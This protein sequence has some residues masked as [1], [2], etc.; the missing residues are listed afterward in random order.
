MSPSI[1]FMGV[2]ARTEARKR[3]IELVRSLLRRRDAVAAP[4][5][6][7]PPARDDAGTVSRKQA[8]RYLVELAGAGGVHNPHQVMA[9]VGPCRGCLG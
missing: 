6:V 1:R 7:P 8:L 5:P 2:A 9:R 4:S 3:R